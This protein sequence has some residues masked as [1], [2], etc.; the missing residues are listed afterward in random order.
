[1]SRF[2]TRTTLL[3]ATA[4]ATLAMLPVLAS[5]P[6]DAAAKIPEV[7]PYFEPTG[8]H[9]GNLITAVKS[10]GLKSFTAAFVL[11]KT[12]TPTW[13]DYS[14]ITGT[15]ARSKLVKNAKTAGAAP[16]ISFGGQSGNELAKVCTTTSKL[17]TAYTKVINTFGA[18]KIDFDIEGAANV[19]ATTVNTR[20]FQAIKALEANFPKLTV[21]L[22]IPVGYSGIET[23]HADGDGITFLKLAKAQ[24][25]R[26]DVVN[27]MTMDYGDANSNMGKAST[28]SASKSL[29]QIKKIW[30]ADTYA[31][32]GITPMIG[33]NDTPGETFSYADAETVVAF[34][35]KNGV[36]RVAFWAINR[37]QACGAGDQAPGTCTN[38]NQ[39]PLD[40]TDAFVS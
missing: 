18:T 19:N 7:A 12:C 1:M 4:S 16:I 24:K 32:I 39:S 38:L 36:H 10:H 17:V 14:T 27:L 34:A 22:T 15:D 2:R 21:S 11:G 13:D 35:K 31:N 26:I 23:A 5:S 9:T 8:V 28:T 25:A 6:A 3:A 33:D 20:R 40:Y 29:A 37:D 30:T